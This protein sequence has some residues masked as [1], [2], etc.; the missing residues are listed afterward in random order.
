MSCCS[1]FDNGSREFCSRKLTDR[2]YFAA[3]KFL[4]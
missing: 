3:H 2:P 1:L 4:I